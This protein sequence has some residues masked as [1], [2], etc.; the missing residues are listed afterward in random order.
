MPRPALWLVPRRGSCSRRGS[1]EVELCQSSTQSPGTFSA[2]GTLDAVLG[3][4]R[5]RRVYSVARFALRW[6]KLARQRG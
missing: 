6:H 4:G 3:A 5:S 2:R 1:R